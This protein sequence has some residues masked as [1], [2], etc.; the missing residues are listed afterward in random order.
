MWV[1]VDRFSSWLVYTKSSGS[2]MQA[3]ILML[4]NFTYAS[5]ANA[6]FVKI[7][8]C[9]DFK[10]FSKKAFSHRNAAYH[11]EATLAVKDYISSMESGIDIYASIDAERDER[12]AE[13]KL[14]VLVKTVFF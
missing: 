7:P 5:L 13:K 1:K 8:A 14:T 2:V 10:E 12:R 3:C 6:A 9:I 4:V 11:N